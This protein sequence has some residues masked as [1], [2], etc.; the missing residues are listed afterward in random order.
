MTANKEIKPS[1]LNILSKYGELWLRKESKSE[2]AQGALKQK[3]K[4]EEVKQKVKKEP[5]VATKEKESTRPKKK[6]K[7]DTLNLYIKRLLQVQN[8]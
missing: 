4:V 3:E 5:K 1:K 7:L 6:R 2:E 8:Q